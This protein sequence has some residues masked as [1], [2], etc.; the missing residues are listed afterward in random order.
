M[1][2]A[3]AYARIQTNNPSWQAMAA[4]DRQTNPF[5]ISNCLAKPVATEVLYSYM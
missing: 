3:T 1:L 5:I 2:H 4:L